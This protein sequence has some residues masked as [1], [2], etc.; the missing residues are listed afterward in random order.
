M[1]NEVQYNLYTFIIYLEFSNLTIVEQ[2]YVL[3]SY[4]KD[5]RIIFSWPHFRYDYP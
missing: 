1:Y 5:K 3:K 4:L 2:N